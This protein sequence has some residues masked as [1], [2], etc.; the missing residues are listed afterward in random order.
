ME[1]KG[2][3]NAFWQ[4]AQICLALQQCKEN[5]KQRK[6]HEASPTLPVFL[7]ASTPTGLQEK[8]QWN[9]FKDD[10]SDID[11]DMRGRCDLS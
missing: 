6:L 3:C 2:N 9:C 7:A 5:I 11:P 1:S 10:A 8:T 4:V